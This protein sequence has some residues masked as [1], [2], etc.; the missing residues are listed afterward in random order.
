MSDSTEPAK[1]P[2]KPERR[3]VYV[4]LPT[5]A[6]TLRRDFVESLL[7]LLIR[8][9]ELFPNTDFIFGTTGGDGVARS[10]NGLTQQFL[11]AT[12]ASDIVFIDVD[13]GFQPEQFARLLSHPVDIVGASYPA[14]TMQH[15]WI[16]TD[17]PNEKADPATGLKKVMETG[18]GMKRYTRRPFELMIA[19]FPEIQYFCDGSSDQ[20]VK[21]DFFSMGVVNGRYL[22]EDYYC[23]YR[24]RKIGLD[25]YVDT[26][27]QVTHDGHIRF[28]FY[29]NVEVF[30]GMSIDQLFSVAEK[31][32]NINVRDADGLRSLV[33]SA[34]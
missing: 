8:K 3:E 5:Y 7:M 33:A 29:S 30:K 24:A 13:I 6:N 26:Q 20:P 21:W 1:V 16:Y 15:R 25:V 32:G 12:K 34:A 22:S 19:A 23:D 27:C 11:L 10:R 31:L 2:A 4:A 17:L 14:K 9:D 18:T 28:P